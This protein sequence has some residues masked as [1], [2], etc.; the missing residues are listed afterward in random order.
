MQ[1]RLL[2]L[3][4]ALT[5]SYQEEETIAHTVEGKP[6]T[7]A[8]YRQSVMDIRA[9]IEKGNYITHENLKKKVCS[10]GK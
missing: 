7:L 2:R 5:E 8:E 9:E 6:L 4:N 1:N 10:W 3:I